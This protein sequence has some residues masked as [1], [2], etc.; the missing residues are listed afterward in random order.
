M[1]KRTLWSRILCVAGLAMIPIGVAAYVFNSRTPP[2]SSWLS[3]GM[4]AVGTAVY[5]VNGMFDPRARWLLLT[6]LILPGSGLVARAAFLGKSRY[7]KSLYGALVLSLCGL[8]AGFVVLAISFMN[9][10]DVANPWWAFVAYAYPIGVIMSFVGAVVVIV[11]SFH[12]PSVSKDN[13]E[14][15]EGQE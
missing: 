13:P 1:N 10:S 3:P 12:R 6:G 11:E 9:Q 4:I 8:I 14:A 7:R 5:V 2:Y 15:T